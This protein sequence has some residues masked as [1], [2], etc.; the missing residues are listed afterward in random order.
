MQGTTPFIVAGNA[1]ALVL[2]LLLLAIAYWFVRRRGGAM[3]V[4]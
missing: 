3:T 1:P 2:A 4:L